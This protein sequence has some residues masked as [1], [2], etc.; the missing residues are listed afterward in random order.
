VSAAQS[1]ARPSVFR[2]PKADVPREGCTVISTGRSEIAVF[3]SGGEFYAI[4]NRCPHRHA[5]L[6][7]GVVCGTNMPSGV[8]E[9]RFGLAGRVVRC[10]WHHF[11]FEL[12]SGRCLSDPERLRVASYEV[13]EDGDDVVIDLRRR[14]PSSDPLAAAR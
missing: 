9:F 6:S 13:V 2:L 12:A 4:V 10:P 14:R 7:A 3:N 1:P 11:E 8:G 5:Q